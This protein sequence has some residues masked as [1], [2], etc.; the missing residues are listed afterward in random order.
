MLCSSRRKLRKNQLLDATEYIHQERRCLKKD[1]FVHVKQ[2]KIRL[3]L[4]KNTCLRKAGTAWHSESFKFLI[5][6]IQK[7]YGSYDDETI[8]PKIRQ[9]LQHWAYKLTKKDFDNEIKRRNK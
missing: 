1:R 8:S 5:T 3:C 6:Q 4:T 9:T 2:I 7:K